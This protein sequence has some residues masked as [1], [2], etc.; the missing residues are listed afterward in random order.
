MGSP[1]YLTIVENIKTKIN[2]GEIKPGDMI[3]SE[4]ALCEEY[5]V[6]RM[7]V[8]KSL[9]VLASEG[10]I[11]SVPGK[12]NFVNEPNQDKYILYFNEMNSIEGSIEDTQ[13]LDVNIVKPT[14]EIIFNL[15]IPENKRVV[16]IRRVFINEGNPVAY[17]I[18]YIPYYR[19]MPI[20]EKEIHYATFPEIVSKKKS[21]F[22]INK[23]LKIK[24]QKPDGK[25]KGIL[26]IEDTEPVMVIEQKLLDEGNKPIGWG[27]TYFK[28]DFFQLQAVSSF[29]DKSNIIY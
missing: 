5:D 22:A 23:E 9:T 17:D 21:L 6:S 25:L 15:Q 12:G 16:L 26:G 10:Y 27:I 19:G 28:G 29:V 3:K 13:L 1:I 8:R 20:V 18:K 11:Y 4:N 24:V 14:L 7:T 2:S